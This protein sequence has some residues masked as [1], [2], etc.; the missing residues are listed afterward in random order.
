MGGK[1]KIDLPDHCH[2]IDWH[3]ENVNETTKPLCPDKRHIGIEVVP[4]VM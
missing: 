2:R 1:I 4:E 3:P